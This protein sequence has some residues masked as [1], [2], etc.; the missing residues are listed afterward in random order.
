MRDR[1]AITERGPCNLIRRVLERRSCVFCI[2][3]ARVK[4]PLT[5]VI[6]ATR[7]RRLER[8]AAATIDARKRLV[9]NAY[10]V[11]KRSLRPVDWIHLPPPQLIYVIPAFRDL[12]YTKP[13]EQLDQAT[14]D[15]AAERLPG[16]IST[17]MNALK[18][19]MLQ[20]MAD[21]ATPRT[22]RG[23]KAK[24]VPKNERADKLFLATSVFSATGPGNLHSFDDVAAYLSEREMYDTRDT[25]SFIP[26]LET[27]AWGQWDRL[28]AFNSVGS[29]IAEA[30]VIAL[31]LDP[32][33][34]RP[35]DLD[36]MDRRFVCEYCTGL[37]V[38]AY[39][40]RRM[41]SPWLWCFLRD[42]VTGTHD[43]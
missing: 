11:Y 18:R 24:R 21:S 42:F 37:D 6:E 9:K 10:N 39:N 20:E 12:I 40:W 43:L 38:R 4:N 32:A 23:K 34:A 36:E 19:R 1:T 2:V 14:C 30:L 17:F 8:N 13:D 25:G 31:G 26:L 15:E 22:R 28:C 3:W 5:R 27:Q 35:Q 41:V 16:Y 33:T 29:Q 7:C